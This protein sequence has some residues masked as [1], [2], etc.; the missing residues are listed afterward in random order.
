MRFPVLLPVLSLAFFAREL[1]AQ[2]PASSP[3]PSLT[4]AAQT[5]QATAVR[6]DT[7]PTIDG[8][9][10][11]AV[12]RSMQPT[13]DF[14]EFAPH[15]GKDPRFRTEFKA[16]Y[17]DRNLYVFVR[18]FDPHPDSIMTALTRR[19]VRGAS[20]QLKVMIDSYHDRRSGFEFAVNPVGVKRD[21]AMY[22]DRE[23]DQSWDGVW[24]AGTRVDSAGWTAEF[25]I[26]LS[27]LR[28]NTKP[29]HTFGFAI[30][31]DLERYKERMSW[32]LYRQTVLGISSQLGELTGIRDIAPFRRREF[33]P[34]VVAKN[35]SQQAVG[36][37]PGVD[38]W[39]RDQQ[40]SA[41]ADLKLG[42]TPNFTLDATV[43]PDFG[44]VEADP[45]VL[46]LSAFE[47]FFQE[48]RPFFVEGSGLYSFSQNSTQVNRSSENLFY[49]R[50]I[51]RAPQLL[52]LYGDEA[53]STVTPII[54]AAK[55]T[56]RLSSGM[57]IGVVE[58]VTGRETGPDDRT[59]E[60][61]TSYT[62][63]RGQQEMRG[64]QSTLGFIGTAVNRSL[65]AWSA[66][67]LRREAYV[68]GGDLRHRWGTQR[69]EVNAKLT[70]SLVRGS[71]ASILGTQL[72]PVHLYQRPDDDLALDPTRTALQG[73]AQEVSLAKWG[74]SLMHW[75]TS[76]ERQSA[77]YEVND[78][79]YLR[80]ANQQKWKNWVGFSFQKPTRVYRR[81]EANFNFQQYW[82]ADGLR[83]DRNLNANGS[84]NLASNH[85]L[86]YGATL[87]QLAGSYCDNCARGGP[88]M[89]S[90]P[91][92]SWNVGWQGDDRRRI[93]PTV[94]YGYG[95]GEDGKSTNKSLDPEVEFRL[96]PQLQMTVGASWNR[97]EDDVQW[98]GNLTEGG[99]TH[100]AFAH[101]SQ[102]TRS[103]SVRVSYAMTPTLTF[104]LYAQ[105]FVSRGQFS[106]FR[107]LSATPRA[108]RY[109]D[110]FTPFSPREEMLAGFDVMELRSNSV[111]RWEFRPGST[112]FVVW[113]HGREGG[114]RFRDR[115]W[116]D[117]YNDLFALHPANTFLVKVAYWLN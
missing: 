14:L 106:D 38:R 52:G 67:Y 7:P 47:Q 31:R 60:P 80:R 26:P 78:L 93:W 89:R 27:Q 53:S 57:S 109:A 113:T 84:V 15:E 66:P 69:Y 58:A 45:S 51:G 102:D 5:R 63:L 77:G 88:A 79:G 86:Y 117:E 74:G 68:A 116:R 37:P 46:N 30:W 62:V 112:M 35:E 65:D 43:N 75:L 33:V 55:L 99:V 4:A 39:R 11:D 92:F 9:E 101:L 59:M 17:D 21:Y 64:G 42:I 12:W 82:T 70:A 34:F 110:R 61:W 95:V 108:E 96:L 73:D 29:E 90:S 8:R 115:P 103:A 49:S 56:G 111:L 44:Q 87:G 3:T 41:G 71:A 94:F 20:D 48:R 24:D 25:R 98:L 40:L 16:A 97:N 1:A 28:Y 10:D 54:G 81:A 6:A 22:N 72:S 105:P 83:T 85:W 18:A 100:Y 76:Y 50:R 19:D 91:S 13:S 104:Q 2:S 36:A 23:E 114:D 32:P 107:E